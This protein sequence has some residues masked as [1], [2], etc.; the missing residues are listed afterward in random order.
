MSIIEQN[1]IFRSN[2]ES[3]IV[4][5]ADY[6][7]KYYTLYNVVSVY[8]KGWRAICQPSVNSHLHFLVFEFGFVNK[9]SNCQ[10]ILITLNKRILVNWPL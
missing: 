7:L 1:R 10:A 6:L 8:A 4:R 9:L 5:G 3:R 2:F